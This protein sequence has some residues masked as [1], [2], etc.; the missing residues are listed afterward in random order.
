MKILLINPGQFVPIKINYPLNTFQPLGIGYM[1]NVLLKNNYEV[2]ILDVL[3]EGNDQEE[4]VENGKYRYVGLC[5][6]EIKKRIKQIAPDI[7]GITMPFTA[8]SKAGHEMAKLVKEINSGMKVVA[9]GSYP[10]TYADTILNDMNIDFVIRGEG[11]LP[12]LDLIQE[13]DKKTK[14]FSKVPG[15][16]FRKNGK[17]VMNKLGPPL[18]D[19]DNYEVAWDLFPMEKYF[20]A[21]KN[22]RSSR[23]I[24]TFGKRWATIYTS[25]GCPFTCSFC[26]GHLVMGRMWRPRS[27]DNVIAEMEYLITKYKVQH[28]DIEDDNFTLNKVRAK[29]ICDK[30]IAKKWKIEWSTPNGIRADT[31]D[32]ELIRKM[33]QSGCNRTIVAPES[34]SQWVVDNLMHKKLNLIKVKKVIRWCKKYKL[35][36]DAFFLIGMPG[37]KKNQIEET[38]KYA[39]E[40]RKIGVDDCGFG[41]LVPHRGTEAYQIA[42]KNN[43]LRSM[44]TDNFVRGLSTGEPMIETPYLSAEDIK[45]MFKKAIKVNQTVPY[46][47]FQ[48]AFYILFHSPKRFLKLSFSYL[49]KQIGFSDGILGT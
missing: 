36:V 23:S 24:S 43:W 11:E 41:V 2:A 30:I 18:L 1:A 13:I 8:Q 10:T 44:E 21:A 5:R 37:E 26:V 17:I 35:P 49:L 27:V 7:T 40:L 14:R 34:G 39:K 32:E 28:F 22:I 3:A 16:M 31:V 45:T 9:G 29:K 6:R 20:E 48:L 47:K 42:V 4:I 46:V 25:R 33:K 38:I 15:L 19:L 12:L